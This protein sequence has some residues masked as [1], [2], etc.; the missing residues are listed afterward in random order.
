MYEQERSMNRPL[1]YQ[2]PIV[3]SVRQL[4]Q[5]SVNPR[6]SILGKWERKWPLW[7]LVLHF[8]KCEQDHIA[9]GMAV[10]D[11]KATS[12]HAP[13]D[14]SHLPDQSGHKINYRG[15]KLVLDWSHRVPRCIAHVGLLGNWASLTP[16]GG[17]KPSCCLLSYKSYMIPWSGFSSIDVPQARADPDMKSRVYLRP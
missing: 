4:N 6:P 2:H 11:W 8:A 7:S 17:G 15:C 1:R 3:G 9:S 10:P 5:A 16:K 13:Q 12:S 14:N